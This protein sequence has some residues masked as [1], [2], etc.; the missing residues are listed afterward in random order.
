MTMRVQLLSFG[1]CPHAPIARDLLLRTLDTFDA[2]AHVEEIDTASPNTPEHL[3]GWGSPT[4]LI[5]G[6]DLES[7]TT[8]N[9]VCCR[10]YRDAEG[11][12]RGAPSEQL[13]RDAITRAMTGHP[14][15]G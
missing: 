15:E 5:D 11:R 2:R 3:R 1:D 8:H 9:G 7:A 12:S 6:V 14:R 4:I 10:L 13:I